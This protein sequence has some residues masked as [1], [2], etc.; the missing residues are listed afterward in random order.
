MN[1]GMIS[2]RYARALL[3]WAD[4]RGCARATYDAAR[5]LIPQLL[6]LSA[7]LSQRLGDGVVS[8]EKKLKLV[9]EVLGGYDEG[10]LQLGRFMVRKG[11]GAFLFRAMWVYV[12]LYERQEHLLPVEIR[13]VHPLGA[14]Q[15][16]R[17]E[18]YIRQKF[19]SNVQPTYVEEADLIG[20]FQLFV[21]GRRYDRSVRGELQRIGAMLRG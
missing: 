2:A 7:A 13:T 17:L 9:E 5:S 21:D 6:P 3:L 16:E 20:G 1:D 12:R 19:G 14:E 4:R 11:R 15:R 18:G 10:L 8:L